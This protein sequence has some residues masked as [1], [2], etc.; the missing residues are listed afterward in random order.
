[1]EIS[2]SRVDLFL[3]HLCLDSQSGS[4]AGFSYGVSHMSTVE[5]NFLHTAN[6]TIVY[7]LSVLQTMLLYFLSLCAG[8]SYAQTGQFAAL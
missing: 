2:E 1:M 8:M 6:Q 5:W 4:L 3:F 7:L